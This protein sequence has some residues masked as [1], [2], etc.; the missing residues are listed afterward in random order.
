MADFWK[1][2]WPLGVLVVLSLGGMNIFL[3]A[4]SR[5]FKLL[6][7][8]N[9]P[10]L[11][12]FLEDK[13]YRQGRYSSRYVRLLAQS[14]LVLG[15]FTAVA[16]LESRLAS[17]KPALLEEN[18]LLFG[19][20]RILGNN[21]A[22]APCFFKSFLDKQ[23]RPVNDEWVRWYYAFAILHTA[24]SGNS[25]YTEAVKIYGDL[26]AN[27]KNML[28]AGIS[29]YFIAMQ[30]KNNGIGSE[31]YALAAQG[32]ERVQKAVKTGKK[33]QVY[34]NRLAGE[35]HGAIIRKNLDETGIWIFGENKT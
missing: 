12:V 24:A 4:N 34:V 22:S 28:I 27:A 17:V 26:A 13:I 11:S 5:L 16:E 3:L 6:E 25:D 23:E 7:K 18:A 31:I 9:W 10:E 20:S 21:A 35:V 2:V 14:Y 30:G 8:E 1:T 33:W 29:A 15:N 19:I 32:K